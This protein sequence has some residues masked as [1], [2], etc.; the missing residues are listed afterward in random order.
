MKLEIE[1]KAEQ[2]DWKSLMTKINEAIDEE[3]T[4]LSSVGISYSESD[5]T[6]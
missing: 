4:E 5:E 1:I 2:I 6:D 3:T